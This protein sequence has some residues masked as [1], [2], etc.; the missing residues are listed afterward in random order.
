MEWEAK[1]SEQQC[2]SRV[3]WR[4]EEEEDERVALSAN[5]LLVFFFY[6]LSSESSF[7]GISIFFSDRWYLDTVSEFTVSTSFTV[8][9]VPT[10]AALR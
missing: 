6:T 7:S 4:E 10:F 9:P 2:S 5:Q 1:V 8:Q 3:G